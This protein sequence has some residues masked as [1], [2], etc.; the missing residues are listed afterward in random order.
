[1]EQRLVVSGKEL[2]KIAKITSTVGIK[3]GVRITPP[4]FN[5]Q[6]TTAIIE[7]SAGSIY[8]F[9]ETIFPRIINIKELSTNKN[10]ITLSIEEL[11]TIE[12]AQAC[13]GMFI[14]TEYKFYSE[15]IE[16]TDNVLRYIGY[17]VVDKNLGR[18]GTIKSISRH[19]QVLL[20][21]EGEDSVERLVPFVKEL[22]EETDHK[23]EIIITNLPG[24]IF[25]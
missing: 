6:E 4:F 10:T 3:G 16:S 25:E 18:L 20:Q 8:L 2:V 14:L 15:Y 1:M 7:G 13:I 11:D 9:S 24:G 17:Q 22:I 12:K 23:D 21:I 5:A 19:G